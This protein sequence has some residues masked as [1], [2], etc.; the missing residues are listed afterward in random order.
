MM[1][2]D[3]LATVRAEIDARLEQLRPAVDEYEQLLSAA[4][5]LEAEE[6]KPPTVSRHAPVVRKAF[7]ARKAPVESKAPVARKAPVAPETPAARRAPV[8]AKPAA[9]PKVA[10]P[11]AAEPVTPVRE[12]PVRATVPAPERKPEQPAPARPTRSESQQAIVAALEHGSHTVAELAV[13]TAMSGPNI[14]ETV[15]GLLKAGKVSKT[16]REGKAAYALAS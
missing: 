16:K 2:A 9:P 15:R 10:S 5:A 12:T 13:V 14:R 8:A 1:A 3:L 6:R 7:V 4:V 11:K